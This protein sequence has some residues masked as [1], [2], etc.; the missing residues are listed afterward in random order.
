MSTLWI[1]EYS[2]LGTRSAPSAQM[3]KM[4]PVTRQ[5]LT[6]SAA[7]ASAAFNEVTRFIG[8][9]VDNGGAVSFVEFGAAPVADDAATPLEDGYTRYFAVTPGQKLSVYDGVS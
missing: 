8:V 6:Y 2:G 7:V 3:P 5:K 4:P 9:Y 1:D